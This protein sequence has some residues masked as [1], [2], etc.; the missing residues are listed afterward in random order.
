M[1]IQWFLSRLTTDATAVYIYYCLGLVKVVMGA[2]DY[3]HMCFNPTHMVSIPHRN[4]V[5]IDRYEHTNK[6]KR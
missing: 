4:E 1:F 3:R 6:E 2:A 5:G